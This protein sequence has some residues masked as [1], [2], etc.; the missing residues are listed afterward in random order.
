MIERETGV[1]VNF[2][3][4]WGRSTSPMVGPY[5]ATK[6]AVEAITQGLRLEIAGSGVRVTSILPGAVA[7]E[8]GSH[9]TD[10]EVLGGFVSVARRF[11]SALSCSFWDSFGFFA[12]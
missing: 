4:G 7:T 3:S 8:L 9:I 5:C 2:S 6:W 1:V 12:R 10:E 11:C